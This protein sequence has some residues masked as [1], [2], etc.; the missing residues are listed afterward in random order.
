ML[1]AHDQAIRSMVWSHNENW[2]VSGDDGGSIKYET[3]SYCNLRII[4]TNFCLFDLILHL[5]VGH[6]PCGLL[7]RYWQNSMN[8]VKANK[9]A[10][11][12]SVRDLRYALHAIHL[13]IRIKNPEM[14]FLR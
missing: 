14:R 10:H 4:F 1:Q 11:K 13:L 3:L 12:E 7:F 8:N 6:E 9:S 5:F 2:M